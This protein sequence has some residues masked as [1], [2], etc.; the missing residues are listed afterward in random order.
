MKN[1]RYKIQFLF[2]E[3]SIYMNRINNN[4]INNKYKYLYCRIKQF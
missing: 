1:Y 4:R 3:T 2:F